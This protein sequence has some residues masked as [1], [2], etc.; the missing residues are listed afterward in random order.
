MRTQ[1]RGN[2]RVRR[3]LFIFPAL[4]LL[5]SFG[6][7][8]AGSIGF[9][10]DTTVH[11]RDI[12]RLE[13]SLTHTGNEAASDVSPQVEINGQTVDG[14]VLPVFAPQATQSWTL[15]FD[16]SPVPSGIDAAVVRI[17][18][19]DLNG[20]P[21]EVISIAPVNTGAKATPAV[22]GNFRVAPIPEN[23]SKRASLTLNAPKGRSGSY[24]VRV[25]APGGLTVGADPTDLELVAGKPTSLSIPLTN[26]NLLVGTAVNVYAVIR[27]SGGGPAQTDTIQGLVRITAPREILT[28]ALILQVAGILTALL[29]I[30]EFATPRRLP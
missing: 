12:L 11:A 21:F 4:L 14:D 26:K 22:R 1:H 5:L 30:L 6:S 23:G 24:N 15:E 19:S 10:V 17:R 13:I 16:P 9:R 20:Y 28:T 25:I 3:A 27:A 18:Y 7:A 8:E 29:L 2:Q